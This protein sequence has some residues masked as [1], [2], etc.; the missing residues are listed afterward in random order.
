MFILTK[1][2][3]VNVVNTDQLRSLNVPIAKIQAIH[4]GSNEA[5]KLILIQQTVLKHRYCW[6]EKHASC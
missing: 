1:W 3:D 4:T 5:K 6:Q 2:F